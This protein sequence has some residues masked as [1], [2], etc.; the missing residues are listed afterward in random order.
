MDNQNNAQRPGKMPKLGYGQ[1]FWYVWGPFIIEWGIQIAVSMAAVVF[2]S[3]RYTSAHPEE[4][5]AAYENRE[6]MTA[7]GYSILEIVEKYTTLITGAAALTVIP[8]MVYF[9]CRDRRREKLYGV[10]VEKKNGIMQYVL[11]VLFAG[12]V[13]FALNNLILIANLSSLSETYQT[14]AESMYSASFAMQILCLG[15]LTPIAEE[16]VFRGLMFRRMRQDTSA[17]L[18]IIYTA[19]VFAIFHGNFVQSVYGFAMG[20]LLAWL[21]EKYGTVLAP[22]VGHVAANL[23]TLFATEYQVYNYILEDIRIV[24]GITV[25]SATVAAILYLQIKQTHTEVKNQTQEKL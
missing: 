9:Y 24:G 13:G 12:L 22:I 8:V 21:C 16:L 20:I 10:F 18:S 3:F 1:R 2:M 17:F 11:V 15:I 23:I 6:A 25:A 4:A 5:L 19:A 14:T 7:L